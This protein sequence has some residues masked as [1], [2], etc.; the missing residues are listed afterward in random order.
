MHDCN[1]YL[2]DHHHNRNLHK[3]CNSNRDN[4]DGYSHRKQDHNHI[5]VNHNDHDRHKHILYRHIVDNFT[6]NNENFDHINGHI[7]D[8]ENYVHLCDNV[9]HNYKFCNIV[10]CDGHN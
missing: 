2:N 9:R 5:G 10:D 7:H 3:Q 4:M 6:N 1:T 8:N